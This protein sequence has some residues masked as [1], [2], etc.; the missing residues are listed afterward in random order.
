MPALPEGWLIVTADYGR[1]AKAKAT[2]LHSLIVRAPG[3]CQR[4]GATSNLQCAHIIRRTY[5]ATRTDEANGWCLCARCH[6]RLDT[7]PDEFMVFV[8]D[9]IGLDEFDRLKRKALDGV[10][11]KFDW[12]VELERLRGV[13]ESWL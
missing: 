4:C 13:K 3:R 11:Q 9:T 1:G 12:E 10:G 8:H 2:K 5:S 7:N 6:F